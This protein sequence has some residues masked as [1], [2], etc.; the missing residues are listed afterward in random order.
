MKTIK[1]RQQGQQ[2]ATLL[3]DFLTDTGK[4]YQAMYSGPLL[5]NLL[6]AADELGDTPAGHPA[7]SGFTD[8]LGFVDH[9]LHQRL[10]RQ[11]KRT[12]LKLHQLDHT[13]RKAIKD[14]AEGLALARILHNVIT[15]EA[16]KQN[17]HPDWYLE[18]NLTRA[19]QSLDN[20]SKL[21]YPPPASHSNWLDYLSQVLNQQISTELRNKALARLRM[22]RSRTK[23]DLASLEVE[24][25]TLAKLQ[26]W[27]RQHGHRNLSQTINALL[28]QAGSQ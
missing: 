23:R 17:E 26:A 12:F 15:S 18:S 28:D 3:A 20:D 10:N 7:P 22:Q 25:A 5:D 24:A 2:L 19:A 8:W 1:T 4:Q 11:D 13:R 16:Q 21:D 14:D 6:L 27:Q 9:A